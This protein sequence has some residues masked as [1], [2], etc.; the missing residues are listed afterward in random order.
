[1]TSIEEA[2]AVISRQLK[3]AGIPERYWSCGSIGDDRWSI[4]RAE[5][6]WSIGYQERGAWNAQYTVDD[7]DEAIENFVEQVTR[8]Y[9]STTLSAAATEKW[10]KERGLERP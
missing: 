9:E 7:T 3:V 10:L 4:T 8:T 2:Y 5:D 1:M 6:S